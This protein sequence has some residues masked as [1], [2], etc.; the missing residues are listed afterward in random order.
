MWTRNL[1][2]CCPWQAALHV[3]TSTTRMPT[4][5]VRNAVQP[6]PPWKSPPATVH[7]SRKVLDSCTNPLGCPPLSE[8]VAAAAAAAHWTRSR[9]CGMSLGGTVQLPFQ[10][11]LASKP[12]LG[13]SVRESQSSPPLSLLHMP[14]ENAQTPSHTTSSW[15]HTN[16]HC[17]S[18]MSLHFFG[19]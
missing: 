18:E 12:Q 11:R 17:C 2:T 5:L 16:T 3:L 13:C 4:V 1:H 7:W 10:G 19:I 8:P 15:S 6:P 14:N 9:R